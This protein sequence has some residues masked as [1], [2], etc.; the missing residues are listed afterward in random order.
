MNQW[1]RVTGDIIHELVRDLELRRSRQTMDILKPEA[2]PCMSGSGHDIHQSENTHT[3]TQDKSDVKA[4]KPQSIWTKKV[5]YSRTFERVNKYMSTW[6]AILAWCMNS[7]HTQTNAPG[8]SG[9]KRLEIS[10]SLCRGWSLYTVNTLQ[11]V[12]L[13]VC[14]RVHVSPHMWKAL[15]GFSL[16]S[17]IAGLTVVFFTAVHVIQRVM[18]WH[19]RFAK[20]NPSPAFTV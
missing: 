14:A 20:P 17:P 4:A 18:R 12:W 7:A 2:V 8:Q 19:S 11:W 3:H 10:S 5:V 9:W 16:N 1:F 6:L 13:C 15:V